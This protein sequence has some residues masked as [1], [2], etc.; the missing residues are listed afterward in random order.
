MRRLIFYGQISPSGDVTGA[1][2]N[3]RDVVRESGALV[4]VCATNH[5]MEVYRAALPD[6]PYG[7][8]NVVMTLDRKADRLPHFLGRLFGKMSA[9][10]SMPVAWVELVPQVPGKQREDDPELVLAIGAGQVA[11]A[12]EP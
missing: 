5:S 12:P 8:A 11:F 1:G 7:H 3:L 9:G 4:V 10:V 6:A 2:Q